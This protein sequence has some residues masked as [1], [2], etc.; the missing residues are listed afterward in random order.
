MTNI[1]F[2][3]NILS[4]AIKNALVT[5]GEN[6][7][8]AEIVRAEGNS[9][10]QLVVLKLTYENGITMDVSFYVYGDGTWFSPWD[11]HSWQPTNKSDVHEIDWQLGVTG[12]K[13]II[14]DNAPRMLLS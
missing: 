12:R 11:W 9:D 14:L 5:D 10:E 2:T 1:D 7:T 6:V 8:C 13:A 3:K 4:E